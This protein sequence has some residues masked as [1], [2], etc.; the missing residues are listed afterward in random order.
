MT[1]PVD[2]L[3]RLRATTPRR[4]AA[5]P[6]ARARDAG[7]P[8]PPAAPSDPAYWRARPPARSVPP[9][10]SA[11][12]LPAVLDAAALRAWSAE[13]AGDQRWRW[14][15]VQARTLR[16]CAA[17]GRPDAAPDVELLLALL[18]RHGQLLAEAPPD[19]TLLPAAGALLVLAVCAPELESSAGWYETA[20]DRLEGAV[21]DLTAHGLTAGDPDVGVTAQ[22]RLQALV[23]FLAANAA[24]VPAWLGGAAAAGARTL[25]ALT[26]A[27]G[28]TAFWGR[29]GGG[30][31]AAGFVDAAGGVAVLRG[32]GDR[33]VTVRCGG[34]QSGLAV[35]GLGTEWLRDEAGV[36]AG[37][38]GDA[39]VRVVRHSVTPAEEVL[40]VRHDHDGFAVTRT[41][42]LRPTGT[43]LVCDLAEVG[44]GRPRSFGLQLRPGLTVDAVGA[45]D[46][47]ELVAPDG[48]RAR[49]T[50]VAAEMSVR[51][52]VIG[53]TPPQPVTR[54]QAITTVGPA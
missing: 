21:R 30:S 41:L 29:V 2:R 53:L 33:H 18:A 17:L 28:S 4:P 3:R 50:A 45:G 5:P 49:V 32:R 22:L 20:L 25:G 35:F 11:G 7:A 10:E 42:R 34:G 14:P 40:S 12:G 51:D 16:L 15:D 36:T 46:G 31:S 13:A 6:R 27:D 48:R 19:G 54:W 9:A 43:L 23:E 1:S 24:Q 26:R 38:G 44:D 37:A 8:T 39:T 52:G 47:C